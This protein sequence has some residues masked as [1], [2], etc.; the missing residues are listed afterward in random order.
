MPDGAAWVK[1][2]GDGLAVQGRC[3][4]LGLVFWPDVA[5]DYADIYDGLDATSGKKFCRI[6]ADVDQTIPVGFTS[7]VEFVSGI[8]V[9]GIDSAVETTVI[10]APLD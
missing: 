4:L 9:D 7:P 5:A 10:F 2:K 6:E 1:I 8:Y 3:L